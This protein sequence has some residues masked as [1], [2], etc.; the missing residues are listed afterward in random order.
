M[1]VPEKRDH[2][3]AEVDFEL[4]I[5]PDCL[6]SKLQNGIFAASVVRSNAELALF[7]VGVSTL[8]SFEKMPPEKRAM[9]REFFHV[10]AYHP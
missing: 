1:T 3:A 10:S 7:K 9:K 2:F 8:A 4:T 6:F 5:W